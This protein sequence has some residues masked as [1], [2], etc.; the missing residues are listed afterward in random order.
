M[1]TKAARFIAAGSD[2]TAVT[3]TTYQHRFTDQFWIEQALDGYK[4]SIQVKVDD[5]SIWIL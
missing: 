1:H 4:K 5:M 2:D 3:T